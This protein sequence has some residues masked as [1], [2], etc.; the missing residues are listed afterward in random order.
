M[1]I[2]SSFYTTDIIIT[3][4]IPIIASTGIIFSSPK[5]HYV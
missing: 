3:S 4:G 5:L 2:F 1:R